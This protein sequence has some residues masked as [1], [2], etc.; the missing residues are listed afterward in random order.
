MRNKCLGVGA[1][2]ALLCPLVLVAGTTGKIAGSVIDA[3]TNDALPGANVVV[4]GTFLGA[5]TDVDGFY[6]INNIPPGSYSVSVSVLG[7]R[8]HTVTNVVVRIDLTTRID[9]KL[10]PEAIETEEVVVRAERP[11]VQKDLTSSSVTVSSEELKRIPTE[12][13]TQVVNIQAGVV[14]GHFRG[15]RSNEVAYLLDGVSVTDPY[16]GQLS[17]QIDNSAIRE[18]EV[19]S[20]TFNAEYGKVMSG[21]VNVVTAEGSPTLHGSLSAYTGDYVTSHTDVFPNVGSIS[22]FRTQNIQG[23]LSG[24]LPLLNA[25]TFFAMGRYY[26]DEGSLFGKRVYNVTDTSPY[27]LRDAL[28]VQIL[29]QNNNPIYIFTHTG[30]GAYVPMNPGT[31]KSINGK[32]AYA[33]PEMKFSYSLFWDDNWN[34]YY[35]HSFAWTPD[36]IRNHYRTN[37]VHSF[38]ITH[39]PSSNTYQALKLSYNWFDY[40]GYLYEDP[41]DP[42]YVDPNRGTPLSGY[43]FRS[44]GN[45]GDRYDRYSKSWTA[46]WSLN[47]QVSSK[48]K[49]GVGVEARVHDIHNH[50]MS[51]L[52]LNTTTT[53]STGAYVFVLGYPDLGAPGNQAYTKKPLELSGFAQDKIEYDMM[54]VNVGVRVDYFDPKSSYPLDLRNPTRNPLFPD[55]GVMKAASTKLQVSPRLG[56]SFPITD[57]GI[58]HFSYG[59]FFQIP[60]FENLY[61][62]SDYLVTQSSGLTNIT[63]NPDLEAQRTVMYELGLQQVLFTNLGLDL[64][65]YYRD[66]RNLLGMEIIN[67]YEG[68][69]YARFINR[70]YSKVKGFV[71]SLDRRFADFYGV[72]LDYTFQIAEGNAS[73]PYSVYYN[74]QTDPPIETNKKVVP[75]DWDQRSTLNLSVTLGKPGDWNVGGILQLGSGFPYTE[76]IRVSNGLRFENGGLRPSSVNVDLR[77]EKTFGWS[78][79]NFTVFALV[80]NLLD[81]KNETGVDAASGRANIDLFTYLAGPVIGLNTIDQ[82]LNNPANFSGPRNV[83]LG[84]TVDF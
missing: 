42:R 34:K 25:V 27:I 49:L 37:W 16:N 41:F 12:N 31:R 17:L 77:A 63:G 36:G 7:Y 61:Y 47:S 84:V 52:N 9:A 43:T 23:S 55:A 65:L 39:T 64:T 67:T 70:D 48:H 10:Q 53:D 82:Y 68:I 19:I 57:Q 66:I 74:N 22:K 2:L 26:H 15:G 6:T 38:Q 1:I 69:K 35:D 59:H 14:G 40:K 33:V 45:Q 79:L 58:L 54:I 18:M 32:L 30:D 13:L 60:S 8:K 3:S 73:D 11:I 75:L 80:Y 24:T 20:G 28:G 21:V 76:D 4:Q 50:G 5:S 83:R 72:R 62:N 51:I 44:G 56:V 78:G 81:T 46:Q 29:D 71:I